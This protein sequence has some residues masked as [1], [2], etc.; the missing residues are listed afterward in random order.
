MT[1][2]IPG[3][4]EVDWIKL[5]NDFKGYYIVNYD[6]HLWEQIVQYLS[7]PDNRSKVSRLPLLQ[8]LIMM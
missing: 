3:S 6:K 2:V 7:N 8:F 5:N 1:V 4:I